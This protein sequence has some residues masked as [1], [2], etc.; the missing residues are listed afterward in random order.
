MIKLVADDPT[1]EQKSKWD[2]YMSGYAAFEDRLA[3]ERCDSSWGAHEAEFSPATFWERHSPEARERLGVWRWRGL[4]AIR[5]WLEPMVNAAMMPVDFGGFACP[6]STS[7]V[8]VIDPLVPYMQNVSDFCR[9]NRPNPTIVD[10]MFSSH[11]LEHCPEHP[12]YMLAQ[13]SGIML[14]SALLVLHVPAW[15]CTRWRAGNHSSEEYGDHK[16]TFGLLGDRTPEKFPNYVPIDFVA[17]QWF[18]VQSAY[19]CGDDS[20]MVLGY[21]R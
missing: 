7:N 4:E 20:I 9:A 11:T 19:H 13:L 17:S 10:L 16:W 8:T 18:D 12:S 14:K 3:D 1:P 5:H 21:R 15:T 6:L 2:I